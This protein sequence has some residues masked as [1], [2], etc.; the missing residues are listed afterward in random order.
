[1]IAQ[2]HWNKL[3]EVARRR[4]DIHI[5]FLKHLLL[6]SSTLFGI[7]A[8]LH[9]ADSHLD[10]FLQYIFPLAMTCIVAGILFGSAALYGEVNLLKR[11]L[12]S[13][14]EELRCS[15]VEMREPEDTFVPPLKIF[16]FCEITAFVLLALAAGLLVVYSFVE[17]GLIQK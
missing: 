9:K 4:S 14:I 16:L 10:R 5:D 6:I 3:E 17:A 11:S 8:A 1:M 15:I 7:L 12:K 2:H 13:R